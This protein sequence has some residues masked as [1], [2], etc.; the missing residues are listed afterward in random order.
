PLPRI[1]VILARATHLEQSTPYYV[2]S[3]VMKGFLQ[4]LVTPDRH[5]RIEPEHLQ[6]FLSPDAARLVPLLQ[7]LAVPLV[8]KRSAVRRGQRAAQ[9]AA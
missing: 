9:R 1:H 7:Y 2:L 4:L 6:A 8:P 3:D 5:G